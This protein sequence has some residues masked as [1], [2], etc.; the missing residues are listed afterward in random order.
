MRQIRVE[1]VQTKTNTGKKIKV[2]Y[3][4]LHLGFGVDVAQYGDVREVYPEF[5]EQ[6]GHP[7]QRRTK[8]FGLQTTN[9]FLISLPGCEE[10][11]ALS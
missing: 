8:S 7:A 5:A 4:L 11:R 2:F 1:N 9:H 10:M 3:L 6:S